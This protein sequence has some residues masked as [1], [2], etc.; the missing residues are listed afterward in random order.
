MWR[1]HSHRPHIHACNVKACPVAAVDPAQC[2]NKLWCSAVRL[3]IYMPPVLEVDVL[4]DVCCLMGVAPC[5]WGHL[6]ESL[7]HRILPPFY[8][9][10]RQWWLQ[11]PT[12][13]PPIFCSCS[14]G[15]A[16]IELLCRPIHRKWS[17]C[18]HLIT[19]SPGGTH[20][21][22]TSIDDHGVKQATSWERLPTTPTLPRPLLP[23]KIQTSDPSRRSYF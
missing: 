18:Q 4:D 20:N 5:L 6:A 12:H 7:P 1:P 23:C 2:E 22:L 13:A 15:V 19:E 14:F 11:S 9:F 17:N 21:G 3:R 8:N 16:C 10:R